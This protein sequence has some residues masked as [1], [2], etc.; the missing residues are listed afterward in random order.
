MIYILNKSDLVDT[1]EIMQKV[2]MDNLKPYIFFSSKERRGSAKL[3]KLIK[4]EAGKLKKEAVNVGV[5]GYPNTGKSSLINIVTGTSAAKVSSV[6]GFTKGIKKI[7]LSKGLYLI[8][9]P[10]IIPPEEKKAGMENSMKHS[11]IGAVTWDRT[12][13][14]E[15]V[16]HRLMQ[17]NPG[18]F[19][20]HYK[21]NAK[22]DS[23][24][25]IEE[26][27]RK[28]NFLKKGN[29]VDEIRTA[30]KIL[31]DW[32]EGKIRREKNLTKRNI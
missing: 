29:E 20:N 12:K 4:I 2:E 16:I 11:Q 10:G 22:G 15:M 23:E 1:N 9:T 14:P 6:A 31:R 7:K 28:L 24:F 32:Q 21:I 26:I 25:L 17:E 27:G 5:V 18:L 8:D 3:R 30:K 19:E 13:Y